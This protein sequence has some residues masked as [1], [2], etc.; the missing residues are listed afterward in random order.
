MAAQTLCYPLEV[1]TTCVCTRQVSG[2]FD[3][4]KK[5]FG[6]NGFLGFYSGWVPFLG[7]SFTLASCA[8]SFETSRVN[9]WIEIKTRDLI[10]EQKLLK[11]LVMKGFGLVLKAA[12]VSL[13]TCPLRTLAIRMQTDAAVET[14]SY[15]FLKALAVIIRN[16][17]FWKGLYR[18][19]LWDVL[20]CAAN[21]FIPTISKFI[22]LYSKA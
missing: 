8:R 15:N 13:V 18:G 2:F 1:I 4:T 10:V 12:F 20:F 9:A 19:Y 6:N 3:A 11:P 21:D 16:E 7:Y 5:I 14:A 22:E 17:G